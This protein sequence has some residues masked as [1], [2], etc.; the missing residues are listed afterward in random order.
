MLPIFSLIAQNKKIDLGGF[1]PPT[2]AYSKGSGNSVD[3]AEALTNLELFISNIIGFMTALGGIFFVIY[4]VLGAFEWIT[5]S[6][7]KGKLETARN[8]MVNGAIGMVLLV[9][10]YGIIGLLGSFIGID[11]LNPAEQINQIYETIK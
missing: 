10:S 8:K 1:T 3:G 4:F 6:G 7:D 5:S 9:A 11:M 2:D